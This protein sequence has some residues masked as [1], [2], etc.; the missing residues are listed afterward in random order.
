MGAVGH[1]PSPDPF[2][3][4]VMSDPLKLMTPDEAAELIGMSVSWLRRSS[5]TKTK[6]GS[7]TMYRR[8]HVAAFIRAAAQEADQPR[9]AAGRA[10]GPRAVAS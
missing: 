7:K 8:D 1:F 3:G 5:L 6:F 10:R 4:S 2:G 9:P